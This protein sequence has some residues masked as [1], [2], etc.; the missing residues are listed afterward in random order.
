MSNFILGFLVGWFTSVPVFLY[1]RKH[2]KNSVREKLLK[3][4]SR[5]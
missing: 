2:Y 1:F 4:A 5:T 3:G